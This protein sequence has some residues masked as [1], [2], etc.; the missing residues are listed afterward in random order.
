MSIS[1]DRPLFFFSTPFPR[2]AQH[3]LRLSP[4]H[5]QPCA[6]VARGDVYFLA[7]VLALVY[8]NQS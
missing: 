1:K 4:P 6:Y 8:G 7:S 3:T 5:A 2:P